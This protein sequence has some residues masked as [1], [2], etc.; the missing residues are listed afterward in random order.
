MKR[1]IALLAVFIMLSVMM[2]SAPAMAD[3]GFT[4]TAHGN[5]GKVSAVVT[6]DGE[7]IVSIEIDAPWETAGLGLPAVQTIAESIVEQQTLDV[8]AVAGAT[9]SSRAAVKAVEN[10]LENAGIDTAPYHKEVPQGENIEKTADVVVVGGGFAGMV[11]TVRAAENGA[12]VILVERSGKL[13]GN[14]RYAMGWI[15][16]A[17]FQIQKELGVEDS[18]EQF[19]EDIVR[20]AGGEDKLYIPG[21]III[22]FI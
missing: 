15:S 16:G 6:M 12:H 8:D 19:Y 10:A 13:G 18:P 2:V 1:T 4:G 20:I 5:N 17:G 11:S 22:V 21:H 14:A 7:H 9:I 3:S